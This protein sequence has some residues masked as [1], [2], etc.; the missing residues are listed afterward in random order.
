MRGGVKVKKKMNRKIAVFIATI[1]ILSLSLGAVAFAED[2]FKN[3]KA[4]FGSISIYRNNQYV[5]LSDK[6]FIVDG[7]TYV[8][9]R[10]ISELFNKEVGWDGIDYRIDLDDKP[11]ENLIYMTQQLVEA[12]VKAQELE[13]KV[14][15]LEAELEAEKETSKKEDLK[16]LESYLNRRHSTYEDIKFNIYLDGNKDNIEVNIY[17]NLR[18][19]DYEWDRLYASNK[20]DYIRDIVDD[21][22]KDF[23]N[24]SIEGSIMDSSTSKNE[25]L[26]SFRKKTSGSLVIDTDYDLGSGWYGDL[27]DLQ[28]YLNKY[29]YKYEGIYGDAYFRISLEDD[30]HGDIRVYIISEHN[31]DLDYLDE[32][33]IKDYI[34]QICYEIE[35]EFSYA[36]ID[37]YIEDDYTEYYFDFDSKGNVYLERRR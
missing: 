16:D 10:A 31:D 2:N 20:R 1:L 4:W 6:P 36:Y 28:R 23:K 18:Y 15:Q 8:P 9:L 13:T 35:D 26:A 24:A 37:G 21:I 32:Y 25:V 5:Q 3:L 17:V 29:H 12:Q 34:R 33:D 7:R 27:D 30:K 22:L 14:A 11:D 19:Y